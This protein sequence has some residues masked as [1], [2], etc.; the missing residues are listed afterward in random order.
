MD[1]EGVVQLIIRMIK[2]WH[3]LGRDALPLLFVLGGFQAPAE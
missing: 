3:K 2:Q 1:M